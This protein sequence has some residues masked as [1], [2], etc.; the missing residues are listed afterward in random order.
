MVFSQILDPSDH[1]PRRITK[2]DK[3]FGNRLDF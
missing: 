1:N 3:N 2:A